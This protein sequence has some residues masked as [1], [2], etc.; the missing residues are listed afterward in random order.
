VGKGTGVYGAD[1]AVCKLSDGT[2]WMFFTSPG[3]AMPPWNL[4]KGIYSAR[5][6]DG[7]NFTKD[8]GVRVS[9]GGVYD[10]SNTYDPTVIALPDGR[11]RMY[12][13]GEYDQGVVTLSALSP[14]IEQ[15]G[16]IEEKDINMLLVSGVVG[17]I[18]A[19]I[20]VMTVIKKR[21][22]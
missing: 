12:Y 14:E 5:S 1:P 13:G 8:L 2:Y 11:F 15:D 22:F 4:D 9:P 17:A 16:Q 20:A 21:I 10:S 19:I 6:T 18:V 7:I 3:G